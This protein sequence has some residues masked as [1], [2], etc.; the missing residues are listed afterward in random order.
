MTPESWIAELVRK[1]IAMNKIHI[2][3]TELHHLN[4]VQIRRSDFCL[5][6]IEDRYL[7]NCKW[8]KT[9]FFK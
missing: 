1:Q 4:L 2:C 3:I 8:H 7:L 6:T 5:A 9:F